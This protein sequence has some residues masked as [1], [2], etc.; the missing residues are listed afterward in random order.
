LTWYD[1]SEYWEHEMNDPDHVVD[2]IDPETGLI[3]FKCG[4]IEDG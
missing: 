2:Y 4:C 1:D 3:Y